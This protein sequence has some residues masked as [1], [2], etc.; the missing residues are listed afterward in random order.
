[1]IVYMVVGFEI[2]GGPNI[3]VSLVKIWREIG[4]LFVPV[5]ASVMRI[6]RRLLKGSYASARVEAQNPP[7]QD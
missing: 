4:K 3:S 2:P 5:L 6:V 1:M 7:M